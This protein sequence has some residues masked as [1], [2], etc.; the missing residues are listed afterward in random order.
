MCSLRRMTL[1]VRFL[2]ALV[3][4]C[5]ISPMKPRATSWRLTVKK[6]RVNVALGV[7]LFAFKIY[8]IV[9]IA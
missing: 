3:S 4:V 7:A 5:W 9:Y 2:S 6:F 1:V 8:V